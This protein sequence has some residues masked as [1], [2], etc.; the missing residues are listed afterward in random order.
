MR[1]PSAAADLTVRR[2][3]QRA[4]RKDTPPIH[5][6]P[7]AKAASAAGGVLIYGPKFHCPP[8]QN[9]G[10]GAPTNVEGT[11]G[12]AMPCGAML[13]RFGVTKPYYCALCAPG[14]TA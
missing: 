4:Q 1:L 5:D 9:G 12:G 10:C 8:G 6:T 2:K 3:W 14:R 13:T 11:N 7:H